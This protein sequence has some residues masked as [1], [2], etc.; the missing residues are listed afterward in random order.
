M[1]FE[2][3][4]VK[5]KEFGAKKLYISAHSAEESINAYKKYGCVFAEEPNKAHMEKESFDLQLE[6][7][8]FTSIQDIKTLI[9]NSNNDIL[10][11]LLQIASLIKKYIDYENY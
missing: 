9:Y 2:Q 11:Y 5:A 6:Y 4:C 7:K 1:L 3:I 8:L 10:S